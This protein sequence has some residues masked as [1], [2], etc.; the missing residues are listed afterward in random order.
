MPVS[1]S[2]LSLRFSKVPYSLYGTYE[3]IR[4]YGTYE[5]LRL[6]VLS[7]TGTRP[8]LHIFNLLVMNRLNKTEFAIFISLMWS[9][10]SRDLNNQTLIILTAADDVPCGGRKTSLRTPF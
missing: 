2:I 9:L 3:N 7:E 5:N 1:L 8:V 10:L 4:L 6:K